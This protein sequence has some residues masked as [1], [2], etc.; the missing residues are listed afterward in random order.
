M[1]RDR[2]PSDMSLHLL[3]KLSD[4]ALG[5]FGEQLRESERSNSL[6]DSRQQYPKHQRFE[7]L[8]VALDD[9]AIDQISG[10]IGQYQRGH[11]VNRHQD[12]TNR[13][14]PATR[15]DQFPDQGKNG[16]Q[17]RACGPADLRMSG[18]HRLIRHGQLA[19]GSF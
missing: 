11:S 10:G 2:Q 16:T 4:Q 18:H 14:Q 7:Q 17:L 6:N 15:T 3:P 8:N 13:Q 1:K 5:G 9:D 12:K 19:T